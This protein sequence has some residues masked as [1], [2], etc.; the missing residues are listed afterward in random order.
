[1]PLKVSW[2]A[3]KVKRQHSLGDQ[4]KSLLHRGDGF[5]TSLVVIHLVQAPIKGFRPNRPVETSLV[6]RLHK[7]R[8]GNYASRHW[9][10]ALVIEL[11]FF[12][13]IGRGIVNISRDDF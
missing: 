13:Q 3:T 1:M 12:R 2:R 9:K 5:R 4:F 7:A 10:F 6:K 11:L 8:Q